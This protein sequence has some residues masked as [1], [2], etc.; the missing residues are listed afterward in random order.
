MPLYCSME[1]SPR[2]NFLFCASKDSSGSFGISVIMHINA[3]KPPNIE[4]N[5][6][7]NIE[8][9]KAQEG[10]KRVNA[11][12]KDH[13]PPSI[14]PNKTPNKPIQK[15]FEDPLYFLFFATC[16]QVTAEINANTNP[17]IISI[18]IVEFIHAPP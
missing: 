12:G 14:N 17:I 8:P 2:S 1:I 10:L 16:S 9:C 3:Y 18:I 7:P 15:H 6:Q 11:A 4:P 5:I 13:R